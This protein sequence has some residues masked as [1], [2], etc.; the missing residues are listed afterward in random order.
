ARWVPD[1]AGEDHPRLSTAGQARH[2]HRRPRLARRRRWGGRGVGQLLP[3][4]AG[5]GGD[6]WAEDDRVPGGQDGRLRLPAGEG[7]ENRGARG[8]GVSAEGADDGAGDVRHLRRCG[9][10]SVSIR[11][12]VARAG[13]PC[14]ENP[15]DYG[16]T[17]PRADAG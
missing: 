17:T 14:Y 12:V 4:L 1:G 8:E 6:A 16:G 2:P 13:S 10:G 5:A 9:Y 15:A 7:D 3:Q 11:L